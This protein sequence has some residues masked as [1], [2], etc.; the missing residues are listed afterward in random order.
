[1]RN[2]LYTKHPNNSSEK[3][4]VSWLKETT[5]IKQIWQRLEQDRHKARVWTWF[6]TY[7]TYVIHGGQL[8]FMYFNF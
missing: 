8:D 7:F 4:I 5:A 2:S 3:Y 1:M 6:V